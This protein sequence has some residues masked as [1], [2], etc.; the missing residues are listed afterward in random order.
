MR[1]LMHAT[2][3]VTDKRLTSKHFKWMLPSEL[4]SYD[5]VLGFDDNFHVRLENI[6]AIAAKYAHK[7]LILLDWKHWAIA[8]AINAALQENAKNTQ[9]ADDGHPDDNGEEAALVASGLRT[10]WHNFEQEIHSMLSPDQKR[11]GYI[12][13]SRANCIS[14]WERMRAIHNA[15]QQRRM[16]N[17]N[18]G[19][20]SSAEF[21][22]TY[23]DTSTILH[24]VSHPVWPEARKAMA[25]VYARSQSIERDQFLLPYFLWRHPK[26]LEATYA[27]QVDELTSG[28]CR[29]IASQQWCDGKYGRAAAA[30][31]SAAKAATAASLSPKIPSADARGQAQIAQMILNSG[32]LAA[33][34]V[35]WDQTEATVT[36]MAPFGFGDR[37]WCHRGRNL[38]TE[39]VK[40][41]ACPIL[42]GSRRA[43][44]QLCAPMASCEA[45][46]YNN[47]KECYLKAK[48]HPY[49]REDASLHG[50]VACARA[51]DKPMGKQLL[52]SS[53]PPPEKVPSSAGADPACDL[54]IDST[55]KNAHPNLK[56]T[57]IIMSHSL[58]RAVNI[59]R[60]LQCYEQM[61]N[62]LDRIILVWNRVGTPPP[63]TFPRIHER[64]VKTVLFRASDN[65]LT[66]RY[67]AA[68]IASSPMFH[69][70]MLLADDD[71]LLS[72][73]LIHAM[74]MQWRGP[75]CYRKCIVALDT[76][77]V[78]RKGEYDFNPHAGKANLA[79][80][81]T[82]MVH[83]HHLEA[84]MQDKALVAQGAPVGNACEDISLSLMVT[85]ATGYVPRFIAALDKE[86][87]MAGTGKPQR[88]VD[89]KSVVGVRHDLP[90][91]GGLSQ[92]TA[93]EKWGARRTAC[94]RWCLVYFGE[95]LRGLL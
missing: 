48:R 70:P 5:W 27:M 46:V 21:F 83:R 15:Q 20:S 84:Y 28:L 63:M 58:E 61:S 32:S 31:V 24:H 54:G 64:P 8:D 95:R 62:V 49:A 30:A 2:R 72:E 80:T 3:F 25:G 65:V 79:I 67:L 53:P 78:T 35:N 14:W 94:V 47:H 52:A 92:S 22:G 39:C 88:F 81:K 1:P 90:Q 9:G 12:G 45:V 89:E 18:G 87:S 50:T 55:M 69:G 57:A 68:G 82:M 13:A 10:G 7:A 86:N 40:D 42:A 29:C 37:F 73:K 16:R 41:V 59:N 17:G 71:V 91:M 6:A 11:F 23:Y 60:L 38:L 4:L 56:A 93:S 75:K 36:N 77:G 66:N 44:L 51:R 74:L 33:T 26:V 19:G 43:C 76:R 34:H 85:N